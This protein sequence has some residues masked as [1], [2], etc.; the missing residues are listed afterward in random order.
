MVGLNKDFLIIKESKMIEIKGVS[1]SYVSGH[2]IID[3]MNLTI[4]D[5]IIFGFFNSNVSVSTL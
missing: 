5:G 2:N 1:Q 4:E 3:N